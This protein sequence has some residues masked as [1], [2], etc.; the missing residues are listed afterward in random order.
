MLVVRDNLNKLDDVSGSDEELVEK[1]QRARE[2]TKELET[3]QAEV[4]QLEDD[5]KQL[6]EK[7]H[8]PES[9][10]LV[11][12][13]TALHKKYDVAMQKAAKVG[14]IKKGKFECFVGEN[15][16][17]RQQ[18]FENSILGDH[19]WILNSHFYR[20]NRQVSETLNHAVETHVTEVHE[21]QVRW[22][23][24]ANEKV[25]WCEDVSGDKY[26]IEAKLAAVQVSY[27]IQQLNNSPSSKNLKN[28]NKRSTNSS[29]DHLEIAL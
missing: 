12:D 10:G 28:K 7:Y 17:G 4:V 9:S 8:S 26:S 20:C 6:D 29:P 15:E 18:H 5:I 22:L 16:N 27:R 21:D 23:S 25:A 2:L 14:L 3:H 19:I 24:A 13:S 1:L 11:K